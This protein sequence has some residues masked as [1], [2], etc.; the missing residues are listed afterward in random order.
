MTIVPKAVQVPVLP[1]DKRQ[2]CLFRRWRAGEIAYIAL[3]LLYGVF[4]PS[5]HRSRGIEQP[6]F[7]EDSSAFLVVVYS[8]RERGC[9]HASSVQ[10]LLDNIVQGATAYFLVICTGHLLSIV[11]EVFAPVSDLLADSFSSTH[12]GCT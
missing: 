9:V 4:Y 7:V 1:F 10:T 2:V 12:D 3:S 6:L 11:F 5:I 8:S